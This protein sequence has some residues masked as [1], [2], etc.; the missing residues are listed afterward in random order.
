MAIPALRYGV[1]ILRCRGGSHIVERRYLPSVFFQLKEQKVAEDYA[2]VHVPLPD[3]MPH[4]KCM[5]ER[6]GHL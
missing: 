2:S 6:V 1:N 4:S 5:G 3:T